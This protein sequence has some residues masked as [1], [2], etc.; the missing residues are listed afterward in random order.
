[1]RAACQKQRIKRSTKWLALM[2]MRV[3]GTELD[4][5][6]KTMRPCKNKQKK[7]SDCES[8]CVRSANRL[9]HRRGAA[10]Q[11]QVAKKKKDTEPFAKAKGGSSSAL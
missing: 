9:R 11:V 8:R 1:M 5:V 10:A 3:T 6:T 4:E 2:Q 7:Q